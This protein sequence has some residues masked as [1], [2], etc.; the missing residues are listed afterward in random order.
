M[1]L[2]LFEWILVAVSWG[3]FACI[4]FF[5]FLLMQKE[6]QKIPRVFYLVYGIPACHTIGCLLTPPDLISSLTVAIP[7]I[8]LYTGICA[9]SVLLINRCAKKCC[10]QAATPQP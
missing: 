1:H 4:H 8:L 7:C 5:V 9:C 3:F 10:E 2:G 6:H